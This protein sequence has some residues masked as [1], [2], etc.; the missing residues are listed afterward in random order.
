MKK[1]IVEVCVCNECVM[2][3]AMDIIESIESLKKLKVQLRFNTQIQIEM[4]K[5]LG[6]TKHG[7]QSP[8]IKVNGELIEKADSETVMAKVIGLASQDIKSI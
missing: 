5:C 7:L 4:N 2:K 1:L 6:E 8:L 3:G